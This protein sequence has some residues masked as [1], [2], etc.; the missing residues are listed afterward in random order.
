M[1]LELASEELLRD[2]AR[3]VAKQYESS[4]DEKNRCQYETSLICNLT[5]G[6]I[7]QQVGCGC[8]H[9]FGSLDE[10]EHVLCRCESDN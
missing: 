6:R 3:S 1:S 4:P 10:L 7:E 5:K 9:E 2:F 8:V